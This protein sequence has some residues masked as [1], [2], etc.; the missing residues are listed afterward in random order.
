MINV[1]FIK[2]WFR[3]LVRNKMYSVTS[4]LGLTIGFSAFILIALFVRFELSWDKS[5]LNY[6]RI[7]RIQRRFSQVLYT[8]NGND[9]SP[10]SRAF[11][12]QMIEG[13]FPEFDMLSVTR[14][15]GAAFLFADVEHKVYD[16]MGLYA[17]SCFFKLFTYQFEAGDRNTALNE[18]FTIVL[19]GNTATRLWGKESA[20]GKTVLLEKKY[21]LKVTGIYKDL[22]FN[23]SL[24][25]DYIISFA[26]LKSLQNI[27]RNDI[28]AGNCMIYAMLKTGVDAKQTE[29]K[30][31]NLFA[32]YENI[33]NEKLELCPLSKVYLN[34]NDRNDYL[35]VLKLFGLIGIFILAMSGF[36]YINLSLAKASM[37]GK[38]VA[39]KK[40][41]G[42]RHQ[43]L[44]FQFLSETVAISL[45]A[46]LFAFIFAKLFLPFFSIIVDKQ[47]ELSLQNDGGFI[48]L[49]I[50]IAVVTGIL[51]GIYPAWFMASN[52]VIKLF[53]GNLFNKKCNSVNLKKILIT[54]QFAISLFL[55][56]LTLS[57]SMQIKY[58]TQKDLGFE[59]DGLLYAEVN[60]SENGVM[61]DQFRSHL[62]QYPEI[63]NVSMSG[64]LPFVRFGGGMTNW[65][66]NDPDI[67]IN[68]RFNQV[69]YDYI[70]VLKTQLVAGRNFSSDF[71]GDIEKACIINETAARCFGWDDPIGKRINDN[72]L[73]VVGV[74]HDFIYQ[75][76][77]NPV[78][79]S[80]LILAPKEMKGDWIF[81]FRVENS[82]HEKAKEIL[83]AELEKILPNDP[84]E[85]RDVPMAFNN[86]NS[87]KIYHSVNKTLLFFTFINVLLA[88]VGMVGLVSYS[89]A[90]RTKEIGIRRING[91]SSLRIFYLLNSEY[92]WLVIYAL[93]IAFPAAWL[94]YNSFPSANKLQAQPWVFISGA[95]VMLVIILISTS[96]ETIK[97]AIRNPA[98]AL[99]YE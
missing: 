65:E 25:P 31:K 61:F 48:L 95:I 35:I 90:R 22:P 38:E 11:T 57:F 67:K 85:I 45:V 84:F 78:D 77:H 37:R 72:R 24:R 60:V 6:D 18:P 7:Y 62:L 55:I 46:L 93:G 15:N 3:K 2:L 64:N 96:Y 34:F 82:N 92:Y 83:T 36:N 28:G 8:T 49:T 70:S 29:A 17:D 44:V 56:V 71:P 41:I 13:H 40:V 86:E 19:S 4:I 54:S 43:S 88:V 27:S 98:D 52:K 75:D 79:P 99:R 69:S 5:H 66:G 59:K 42:S 74:V 73:T 9:V 32:N 91:S 1:I 63:E 89:V 26:T 51:S 58:I 12:A 47:I 23:S 20:L 68:C 14:E 80:V 16:D 53:K 39:V 50:L 87:F 30:I 33:K 97:A 81:G 21:P 10:H 76:M 94:A